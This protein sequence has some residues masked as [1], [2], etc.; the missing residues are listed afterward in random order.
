MVR[1]Q[2]LERG[3]VDRFAG[4]D[5]VGPAVG[6]DDGDEFGLL[7]RLQRGFAAGGG[8]GGFVGVGEEG[9]VVAEGGGGGEGFDEQPGLGGG[10]GA[11]GGDVEDVHFE[12][13]GRGLFDYFFDGFWKDGWR[14]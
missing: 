11:G 4:L 9:L 1:R 8:R 14:G 10:P 13:L 12:D 6:G 7:E 2:Q 3:G 5:A